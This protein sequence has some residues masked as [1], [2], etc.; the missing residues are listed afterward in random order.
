[1]CQH[2]SVALL[3]LWVRLLIP[4]MHTAVMPIGKEQYHVIH[5]CLWSALPLSTSHTCFIQALI[6]KKQQKKQE[7]AVNITSERKKKYFTHYFIFNFLLLKR[8]PVRFIWPWIHSQLG[9]TLSLFRYSKRLQKGLF[10][11]ES[12]MEKIFS[13][14]KKED[15]VTR[16]ET[17]Q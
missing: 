4:M 7:W 1:M 3:Q 17:F 6:E 12:S 2:F 14:T 5:A 11:K 9:I 10:F 13:A 16:V 15:N 8:V